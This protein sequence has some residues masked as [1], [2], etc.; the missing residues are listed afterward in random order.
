MVH[1][2]AAIGH[3]LLFDQL[4][5]RFFRRQPFGIAPGKLHGSL[6]D[7]RKF[8]HVGNVWIP[9]PAVNILLFNPDGIERRIADI[10][11]G[12]QQ[13]RLLLRITRIN[14]IDL[15]AA[16]AITVLAPR[17]VAAQ[18]I[19]ILRRR[20]DDPGEIELVHQSDQSFFVVKHGNKP[21][22]QITKLEWWE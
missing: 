20:R 17:R 9:R 5:Q 6:L 19:N 3:A 10:A 11:A 4:G 15:R 8:R 1:A 12:N 7:S 16:V 22:A 13:S 14:D 18:I 21:P 2:D